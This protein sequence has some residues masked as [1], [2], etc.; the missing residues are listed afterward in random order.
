MKIIIKGRKG[1]K[2]ATNL[3]SYIEDKVA[4]FESLVEEPSICEVTLS[5]KNKWPRKGNDKEVRMV[6]SVPKMKSSLYAKVRTNDF[7]AS[8][9]LAQNNI[10]EQ[11]VKYKDKKKIGSRFPVKYWAEKIVETSSVGPK[12]LWKKIRR[13][14]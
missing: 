3:K 14:R 1:L 5:E 11:L 2:I 12:W 7:M 6:I 13:K 10:E 9:D 4:K 8:V